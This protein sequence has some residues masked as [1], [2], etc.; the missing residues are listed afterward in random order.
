MNEV[1]SITNFSLALSEDKYINITRIRI[2]KIK[3]RIKEIHKEIFLSI[4]RII[5]FRLNNESVKARG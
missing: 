3:K 5:E 2:K 1:N 4:I